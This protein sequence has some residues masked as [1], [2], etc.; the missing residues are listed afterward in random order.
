MG[1]AT[2]GKLAHELENVLNL[3]RNGQLVLIHR[4]STQCSRRPTSCR[5]MID[6][7]DRSNETDID[8]SP[9]SLGADHSGL[10]RRGIAGAREHW[11]PVQTAEEFRRGPASRNRAATARQQRNR[12]AADWKI[13]MP[14][15]STKP[16]AAEPRGQGTAAACDPADAIPAPWP[17]RASASPWAC[18]TG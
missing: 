16:P 18:S 6:N 3:V 11:P 7:I 13:A 10:D 5:W 12:P 4:L 17:I 14:D 1:F 2:L 15:R 9:R 8:E